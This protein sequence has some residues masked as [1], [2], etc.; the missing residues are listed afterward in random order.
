[1]LVAG[2]LEAQDGAVTE[3]AVGG[4]RELSLRPRQLH[5][6]HLPLLRQPRAELLLR[7]QQVPQGRLAVISLGHKNKECDVGK[8]MKGIPR[9]P[10]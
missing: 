2:I 7:A 6:Q 3:P 5:P 9:H 10:L 4:S 8:V 1:M